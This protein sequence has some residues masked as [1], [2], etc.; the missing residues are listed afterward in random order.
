METRAEVAIV[1]GGLVGLTLAVAL[2]RGGVEAVVVDRA[3]PATMLAPEHD[4]RASAIAFA[5]VRLLDGIGAWARIAES[6]PILDIRVS[7]GDSLLCLHYDHRELAGAPFG[8]MVENRLLRHALE[9][10]A[11]EAGIQRVTASVARIESDAFESRIHLDDG[12]VVRTPMTVAADGARSKVRE[13]AGISSR[14]WSYGQTGIVLTVAHEVPHGGIAH[15]RFL[16]AGPFAILP[17]PGN[18]S[19]LVWTERAD[20]APAILALDDARFREELTARFGSFLGH[21]EPEGRR[22]SYPLGLHQAASYTAPRLAV[23]GDA[24]HQIHP[25]AGQGLN[26][27]LRDAA[28][29]AEVIVDARCL[30]LDIGGGGVLARYQRWR[31]FDA[32]TLAVVTDGLNRLFSNDVAPLRMARDAGL[33]VVDRI[34]AL[35]RLF[36][37]HARG[38]VGKLPKLLAGQPL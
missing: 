24:A 25:I 3:P 9:Q 26:L 23:A 34:P 35:K 8:H 11:A 30:G 38:T 20:L 28:A 5:T 2:A 21:L 1:G 22:W 18:R 27:G 15:E 13:L 14:G 32:L 4:G 29:L 12:G 10:S 7:D 16:P 31:R 17:L 36:V 19:S 33:A 37:S 6:Q